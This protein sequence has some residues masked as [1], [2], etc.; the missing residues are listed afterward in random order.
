MA[1]SKKE[2]LLFTLVVIILITISGHFII[3][4]ALKVDRVIVSQPDLAKKSL[5]RIEL[6]FEK[7][8]NI[9]MDSVTAADNIVYFQ[10]ISKYKSKEAIAFLNY[11]MDAIYFYEFPSCEFI[12]V[13]SLQDYG[14]EH[15]DK[16]QGFLY[17]NPDSIFIYTYKS[18]TVT[19]I[20]ESRGKYLSKALMDVINLKR[21]G[22]YP[23]VSTRSPILFEK[24]SGRL[25]TTGFYAD[26]GGPL[27]IDSARTN[28][29]E[30]SLKTG[31]VEYKV[32]YPKFYWGVNWGG[33]GGFRQSLADI[34]GR[35]IVISFMADHWLTTYDTYSGSERKFYAG[36]KYFNE[37]R[38]MNYPS[39]FLS[40]ANEYKVYEYYCR[41]GS[42]C[43]IKYDPYRKVYY[44][45]AELPLTQINW[46]QSRTPQKQKSIILLDSAFVKIGEVLFSTEKYDLNHLIVLPDGLYIKKY[47]DQ[48][49]STLTLSK[50]VL[51]SI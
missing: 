48:N 36:S 18:A 2:N 30:F 20:S 42:Y 29:A 32:K 38:S 14:F 41:E 15:S 8:F 9:S 4:S 34:N 45:V 1:F 37:I 10:Y 44:R 16:I 6:S 12:D 51:K 39:N 26:E 46:N 5:N 40:F 47:T 50:F 33:G 49:S 28:I 13:L 35:T 43:S 23:F 7:D 27:K 31:I 22:V 24:G 19:L 21:T 11:D 3:K 25:Y 17:L